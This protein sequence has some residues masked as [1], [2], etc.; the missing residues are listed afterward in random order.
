[1]LIRLARHARQDRAPAVDLARSRRSSF[2]GRLPGLPDHPH[3]LLSLHDQAG[4]QLRRPRQL[5]PSSP[6]PTRSSRCATTSI[7]LVLLTL[8][9]VGFGLLIA[10][11]VDR[12]RY[13]SVGQ[14]DHLPARWRSASSAPASSGSSCT[15]SGRPASRR[16]GRSTRAV[17][18]GRRTRAVAWLQTRRANTIAL[19]IVVGAG[20]GPASA[21]SSCPPRSR[22]S[23]PNCSRPPASTAPTRSQVFRRITFPLLLPTIAVVATTMVIT[24][25]KAFDIVYV[26]T[27]GNY[28]TEVVANRMIKEMFTFGQPGRASAIAVVLLLSYRPGHGHQHPA[29]PRPGGDPMTVAPTRDGDVAGRRPVA[30]AARPLEPPAAPRRRSSC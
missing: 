17:D 20:S 18:R 1:M 28:D 24:S 11:L 8:F 30:D 13:E 5:R 29:V 15:T 27:N 7:W 25:L 6:R 9:A 19:I 3:H 16:P 14:V 22:A 12:V 2:L 26:M 21:W 23:A 10:V 4:E